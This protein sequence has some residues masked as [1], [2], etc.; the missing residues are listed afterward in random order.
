MDAAIR[1]RDG[2][3]FA[4][5]KGLIQDMIETLE[6][7]AEEDATEKASCDTELAE[8]SAKKDAKTTEIKKTFNQDLSDDISLC[9]AE[10]GSDTVGKGIV[11][12]GEGA[13]RNGQNHFGRKR[14][15]H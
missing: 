13:G 9:S 1:A 11:G 2:D 6:K 10:G 3:P 14:R 4:K 7:E 15:V 8:T 12:V 5:V